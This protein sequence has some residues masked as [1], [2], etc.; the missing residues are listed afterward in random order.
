MFNLVNT[1]S[2]RPSKFTDN[3][4]EKYDLQTA[5][6]YLG[7]AA[8]P[9]LD[10]FYTK[11]MIDW[12]F[13]QGNQ[14]VYNDDLEAFLMDES[15]EVRNRIRFVIDITSPKIRQYIGNV[16]RIDYNYKALSIS[17]GVINRRERELNTMFLMTD[18]ANAAGGFYKAYMQNNFPIG[19]SRGETE[20]MFDNYYIDE[21]Q[22]GINDLI[23]HISTVN[24]I[25]QKKVQVAEYLAVTG[26]GIFKGYEQNGFQRWDVKDPAYFIWD[27]DAKKPDFRDGEYMGEWGYHVPTELY[28]Q[29][30]G[31]SMTNKKLIDDSV[32]KQTSNTS[33]L[34]KY[35]GWSQNKIGVCEM[36]W[37][38]GEFQEYGW[39]KDQYGYDFFTRINGKDGPEGKSLYTD[40]DL[41]KSDLT[42]YDKILGGKKKVKIWVDNLRR[43]I[44]IPGEF[45]GAK[46]DVCLESG[47]VP[48][49]EVYKFNPANVEFPYKVHAFKYHDGA[50]WSPIDIMLDLQRYINRI[51]S[52]GESQMNN[53]RGSGTVIA[54][55]AIDPQ[56]GGEEEIQRNI[57]LNKPIVVDD[58]GMGVQ[59]VIGEYHS[60]GAKDNLVFYNV[61]NTIKSFADAT[62]G[63]NE[64][65]EGMGGGQRE[66]KA[67]TEAMIQRGSLIQ[68]DYYFALSEILRLTFSSMAQQGKQI[69]AENPRMMAIMTGDDK[70]KAIIITKDHLLEDFRVVVKRVPPEDKAIAM[71]EANRLLGLG[72]ID[73]EYYAEIYWHGSMD[74]VAKALKK[75]VKKRAELKKQMAKQ[76]EAARLMGQVDQQ[77]LLNQAQRATAVNTANQNEQNERDRIAKLTGDLVKTAGKQEM[78]TNVATQ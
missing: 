44:F 12:A 76:Q 35:V 57:N 25:E 39:V 27:V 40:K 75:T 10:G 54:K 38:D 52:M 16:I 31:I 74:D 58:N 21:L 65:M 24:E 62:T 68:E 36:Y 66:L 15:G 63:V 22:E 7:C 9:Y 51:S 55:S 19:D 41:I 5:K 32:R 73:E 30:Q 72:L 4:D 17:D 13:Y 60:T 28:E 26:L 42:A 6:Y 50:V 59:N 56:S 23:A 11:Q 43:C 71:S 47:E 33:F 2:E 67:V 3:K 48:Y 69:Y 64:Q 14:W 1:V 70:A 20:G 37:K 49:Q 78:E 46:D 53:Q 18:I 45:I 61:I 77:Q 29:Y 34:S 8:N